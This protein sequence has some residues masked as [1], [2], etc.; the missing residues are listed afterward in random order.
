LNK[1][2]TPFFSGFFYRSL[3]KSRSTAI[4]PTVT[5]LDLTIIFFIASKKL[6]F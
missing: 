6:D 5:F 3:V 2:I 1:K 4:R